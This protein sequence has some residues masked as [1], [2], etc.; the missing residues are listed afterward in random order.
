VTGGT[1]SPA[2]LEVARATPGVFWVE[3]S[4]S[5]DGIHIWHHG[6]TGPGTNRVENGVR[7]ER[8]SQG[9]YLTI[10]GERIKI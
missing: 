1:V 4:P 9:R 5:G 7:I 3:L 10:T 8:Y 2:A 6:P